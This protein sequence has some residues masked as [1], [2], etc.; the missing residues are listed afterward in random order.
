MKNGP[1]GYYWRSIL[2]KNLYLPD[3]VIDMNVQPAAQVLD[4]NLHIRIEVILYTDMMVV[5]CFMVTYVV[6]L[7]ARWAGGRRGLLRKR[8]RDNCEDQNH[9]K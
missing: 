3:D 9:C 1:R 8:H 2:V 7:E 5:V 4:T 6:E